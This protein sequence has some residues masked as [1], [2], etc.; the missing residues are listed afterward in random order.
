LIEENY[1]EILQNVVSFLMGV[2]LGEADLA[3]TGT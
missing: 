3:L 1:P 2:S